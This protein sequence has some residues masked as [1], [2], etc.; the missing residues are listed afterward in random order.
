M[1][2]MSGNIIGEVRPSTRQAVELGRAVERNNDE[3]VRTEINRILY[4]FDIWINNKHKYLIEPQISEH[5]YKIAKKQT[6]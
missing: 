6:Q 1:Q 5:L 2:G 4:S 3:M